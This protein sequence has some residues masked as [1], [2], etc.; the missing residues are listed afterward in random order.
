MGDEWGGVNLALLNEAE[1][2]LAVAAASLEGKVL[3]IHIR[4]R[5]DLRLVIKGNHR[6][7]SIRTGA[8]PREAEGVIGAR[9][10]DTRSVP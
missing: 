10:S 6:Y 5:K 1:D 9:T 4:K 7:N 2:L 8:L 3:A